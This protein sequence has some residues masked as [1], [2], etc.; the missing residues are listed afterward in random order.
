[1]VSVEYIEYNED[2]L[3]K[4]DI[5]EKEE[6][7]IMRKTTPEWKKYVKLGSWGDWY[8]AGIGDEYYLNVP[9]KVGNK[10]F[11]AYISDVNFVYILPGRQPNASYFSD[12]FLIERT[13]GGNTYNLSS[14]TSLKKFLNYIR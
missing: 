1:M 14:N 7:K 10:T 11:T 13:I 4:Y 12:G 2:G 5:F 9:V 6:K 3:D 8:I